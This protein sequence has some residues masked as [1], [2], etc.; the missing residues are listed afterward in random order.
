MGWQRLA[1]LT[2]GAGLSSHS[3][4]SAHAVAGLVT[5]EHLV[6][7]AM[8]FKGDV[9]AQI[10]GMLRSSNAALMASRRLGEELDTPMVIAMGAAAIG[11]AL[12]AAGGL[13]FIARSVASSRSRGH[14][15][16][17][18]S[19]APV[20]AVDDSLQVLVRANGQEAELEV[21]TDGFTTYEDLREII[22]EALPSMFEDTD[23][24]VL[25]YLNEKASWVRVKVKTPIE[26][27]K[28]SGSIK[29]TVRQSK[30]SK[31]RD[32]ESDAGRKKKRQV[33]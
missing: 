17:A 31:S 9:P 6:H 27:V 19:A 28:A 7:D 14:Y 3:V 11:A 18:G 33:R 24:L 12:L 16:A 15:G 32:L 26:A 21:R 29:I 30:Q 22:V 4:V 1:L 20:S 23:E 10:R 2:A 13:I 8:E 5:Q 25:D